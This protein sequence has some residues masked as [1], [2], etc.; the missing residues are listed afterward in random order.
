MDRG[1]I[2]Y[3]DMS[4]TR[5]R[6]Q[7]NPRYVMVLTQRIF[8]DLGTPI[9]APITTVGTFARKHGFAVSL[10]G[11][12]TN[13]TGTI[14]CHQIRSIDLKDRGAR[15]SEKAPPFIVNEVLSKVSTLFE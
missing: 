13:A 12:G 5:G 14:L 4:P 2:W 3:V 7:G 10:S 15:F 11:A 8:N 9:I 1:D 6:E